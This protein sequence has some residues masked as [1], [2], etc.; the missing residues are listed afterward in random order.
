MIEPL[1]NRAV[2]S[3]RRRIRRP[4]RRLAGLRG[5]EPG[6]GAIHV[7]LGGQALRRV[8]RVL[9][10]IRSEEYRHRQIDE[11]TLLAD[12]GFTS[13]DMVKVMLEIEA[14]FDLTIP[15]GDITPENLHKWIENPSAMKPMRPEQGTGMPDLPLSDSEISQLVAFVA[16]WVQ[17]YGSLNGRR[18][19]VRAV[20]IH[21][22]RALG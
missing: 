13:V 21:P 11:A 22:S 20:A 6:D 15:Q 5:G 18:L 14:E 10:R 7:A 8:I 19:H 12:A 9:D 16:Q 4:G 17:S 3:R 1:V 2:P